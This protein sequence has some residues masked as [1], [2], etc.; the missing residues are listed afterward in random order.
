MLFILK[1][2]IISFDMMIANYCSNNFGQI[3]TSAFKNVPLFAQP[4]TLIVNCSAL[5]KALNR[6][7]V[8]ASEGKIILFIQ[9]IIMELRI[10]ITVSRHRP[11]FC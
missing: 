8:F 6:I 7:I 2:A 10:R 4:H 1:I 5:W 3:W 11:T 9:A